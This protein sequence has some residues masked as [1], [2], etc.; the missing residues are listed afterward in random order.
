MIHT[1]APLR[2]RITLIYIAVAVTLILIAELVRV[3]QH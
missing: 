3:V 1:R 2:Y